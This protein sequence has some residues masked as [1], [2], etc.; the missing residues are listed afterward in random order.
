MIKCELCNREFESLRSLGLHLSHS[1]K[2]FSHKEYYDKYLKNDSDG[3]CPVCGK[4]TKWKGG[5][6]GYARTCSISCGQKHPETRQKMSETN[7]ERYGAA[8][9]YGSKQIRDKIKKTNLEHIGVENPFQQPVV[10]QKAIHNSHTEKAEQKRQNT[11]LE[12]YGTP[13]H[14]ASNVVRQKSINTYQ[15]KYG[16]IN[17]Y[18]IPKIHEKALQNSLASHQDNGN[19]SSWETLLENALIDKSIPYKKQYK[20]IRYPYYCDFYIINSD[21][22][23]EINGFWMHGK[24]YF[25]INNTEDINKLKIWESKSNNKMYQTAINVW[26]ISDIKKRDTAVANNLN[27]IVLW[28]I[29]DINNFIKSL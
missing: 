4:P 1:H 19:H 17:A 13:Y 2:E 29:D 8:N 21:T 27:Y 26:T 9:P 10:K 15:K 7:L 12:K 18:S 5:L 3:I 11:N 23:I 28:T 25:D 16:V 22:F 24:H 20:D 6:Q 14:I